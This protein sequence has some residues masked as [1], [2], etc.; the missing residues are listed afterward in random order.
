[1]ENEEPLNLARLLRDAQVLSIWEGTTNVL[2]T[3]LVGMLKRESSREEERGVYC[4]R[5][6]VRE[7]LT[8]NN[9]G[10]Q[11]T[12]EHCKVE[13]WKEWLEIEGIVESSAPSELVANGRRVMWRLAW[14]IVGVCFLVDARM[15]NDAVAVELCR[16]WVNEGFSGEAE[17]NTDPKEDEKVVFGDMPKPKL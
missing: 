15:D 9:S 11:E 2:V 12:L 1:M 17:N 6:W 10:R 7:N 16:R 8:T 5:E 3:D 13:I 14:V 4:V